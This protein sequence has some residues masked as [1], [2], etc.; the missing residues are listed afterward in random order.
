VKCAAVAVAEQVHVG[1][2]ASDSVSF[3]SS[4]PALLRLDRI[5]EEHLVEVDTRRRVNRK[6]RGR[7]VTI[8]FE[9]P[10][11]RLAY[12]IS[13]LVAHEERCFTFTP[14]TAGEHQLYVQG[15]ACSENRAAAAPAWT[16]T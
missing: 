1:R 11:G 12:Q 16:S 14:R 9:D 10:E 4:E 15:K 7:A 13:E 2:I 8:R 3:A 5:G 6:Q